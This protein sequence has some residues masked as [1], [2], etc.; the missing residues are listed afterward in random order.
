MIE[1]VLDGQMRRDRVLGRQ[2]LGQRA[3]MSDRQMGHDVLERDRAA[4]GRMVGEGG[5][6]LLGESPDRGGIVE[7]DVE[8]LF[9]EP[10]SPSTR[11]R[12]RRFIGKQCFQSIVV[13]CAQGIQGH[14]GMEHG[15]V[16][17]D[18]IGRRAVEPSPM[19]C[20]SSLGA[21]NRQQQRRLLRT[22]QLRRRACRRTHSVIWIF[23]SVGRPSRN[24]SKAATES[25]KAKVSETKGERST[26]S[27]AARSIAF[28]CTFA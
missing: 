3:V 4:V 2:E 18:P 13:L 19:F 15:E 20:D 22:S 9:P 16:R 1:A 24:R 25:S 14:E 6:D 28:W 23:T 17:G 8:N 26:A 12:D 7:R 10:P 5:D 11:I 21:G 27:L